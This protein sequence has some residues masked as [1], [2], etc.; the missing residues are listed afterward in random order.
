MWDP[1]CEDCGLDY[2]KAHVPERIFLHMISATE[3]DNDESLSDSDDNLSRTEFDTHANMVVVGR[4][5]HILSKTGRKAEVQ[6][7]SPEY[8]P[9]LI[10]IVD[11]AVLYECPYSGERVI[12]VVRDA[13]HVPT[14]NNNLIPPFIMRE[15]GVKVRGTPKIHVLDPSPE[16]H[17]IIFDETEFK[18]PLSLHGIFSYFPTSKP[19]VEDLNGLEDVYLITPPVW[20][21]HNPAYAINEEGIT[22]WEGGIVEKKHRRRIL[23]SDVPIDDT[24]EGTVGMINSD[25]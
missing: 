6:P 3:E 11:A 19:T 16:D 20:N 12:L 22:D 14:M 24:L 9:K 4:H 2:P 5:A 15:A 1:R 13:L 21:P 25:A 23:L 18:I 10:P 8:K 7:Y 17:A